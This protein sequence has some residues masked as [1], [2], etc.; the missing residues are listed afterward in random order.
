MDAQRK[1]AKGAL[2]MA[3]GGQ[4]SPF[5]IKGLYNKLTGP[6][7]TVSQKYARQD[8]ERAAK[9]PAP[10][11][12]A[13]AAPATNAITD[14]AG[15]SALKR[16]E[17]AAGLKDGGQLKTGHG[18]AVPGTGKGDKVPALYEPGEF[19]VSNAMFE[20][21]SP[22]L[23]DQLHTL[24]NQTLAAQGKTPEQAEA[25]RFKGGAIRAMAD[26]GQ[27]LNE[28]QKRQQQQR[29][30]QIPATGGSYA[31][32]APDGKDNTEFSRNVG[33]ALSAMP[34]AAPAIGAIST[35]ARAAPVVGGAIAG[36]GA[37]TAQLA[38]KVAPYAVPAAGGAALLSA[39]QSPVAQPITT[40]STTAA[41]VPATAAPGAPTA[42]APGAG[43]VGALPA[44]S[45]VTKTLQP[46]GTTSYSGAPNITGDIA[47]QNGQGAPIASRGGVS[48]MDTSMGHAQNL[49]D[50]AAIEAGKAK[51]DAD[52]RAQQDYTQNA[53]LQERALKGN[54]GALQI[55]QGNAATATA[56]R[57]QDIQATQQ[58]AIAKLASDKFGLEAKGAGLDNEAKSNVL[59]AQAAIKNAKTPAEK[60]AAEDNLR[61]LQ[62]KYGKEAPPE[63]YAFA[64]GGQ[65]LDPVTGQAITQPGV[66]FNKATGQTVQPQGQAPAKAAPQQAHINA[67]K[68]DPKLAA[69]FDA[70]FGPGAAAQILGQK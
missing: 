60:V 19:V 32:P 47:L 27:L 29:I 59:A 38:S 54:R 34:G 44:Q 3:D 56:R 69:Q 13:P 42:S 26:G 66:I 63:Q 20:S 1:M 70:K 6:S 49:R 2:R 40:A 15:N 28:E 36:M 43:P 67:L 37:G 55:M 10:A 25:G 24:R 16:R 35:L 18:G 46:N 68:A 57:A 12:S 64:P 51:Q 65:T 31:T 17:A 52:I 61:A 21:A 5:S 41:P 23:R 4:A 50:L 8:A 48:S 11:A 58:G 53:M 45:Q 7:E 30:A 33:N 62:G 9:A 39:S 22:E 14:Y